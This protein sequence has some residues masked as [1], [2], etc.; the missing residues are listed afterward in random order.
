MIIVTGANGFIGSAL[1]WEL[2]QL[3]RNDVVC[4]DTVSLKERPELLKKRQTAGF[5]LKDEIW[6]FLEEDEA[7]NSVEAILHMGACSSTTEMNV[8]FLNEN[9]VEYTRRLWQWCT[10]HKK[11]YIY[12]SSAA[13]YGDGA[14]GFDDATAPKTF[15]PLNPYGESKAAFDRWAVE[16]KEVPPFWAGL[17]FFNVYGPNE[18]HKGFQSS[19]VCKAFNEIRDTG[20]LKLFKSHRPEYKDGQQLRDFVYVKDVTRWCVELLTKPNLKSGIYNMGF[21]KARTWLDLANASFHSLEKP[22]SIDWIEIPEIL[23]DKYQYFT[24]AKMNRLMELGLSQPQWSLERGAEDYIK[25]YLLKGAQ[26]GDPYL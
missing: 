18:Y 23:R 3:G 20:R 2:N 26:G 13:V 1:V 5:L 4:V 10:R 8:D 24:E 14:H 16:Q 6:G 21:G 15:K 7:I 22:V 25:N 12:A 9:N 11:T 17:R 19:V